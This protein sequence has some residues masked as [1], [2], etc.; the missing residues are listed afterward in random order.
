MLSLGLSRKK[1]RYRRIDNGRLCVCKSEYIKAKR[2]DDSSIV[3]LTKLLIKSHKTFAFLGV[4]RA[5][6]R[7][8]VIS[9]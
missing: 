9:V 7:F 3:S 1:C 5:T 6:A 4:D 8:N 2:I